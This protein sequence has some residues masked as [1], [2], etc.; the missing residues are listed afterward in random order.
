[1]SSGTKTARRYRDVPGTRTNARPTH[2]KSLS[3]TPTAEAGTEKPERIAMAST[4]KQ[5]GKKRAV[6]SDEDEDKTAEGSSDKLENAVDEDQDDHERNEAALDVLHLN[7]TSEEDGDGDKEPVKHS[8]PAKK[9]IKENP[10]ADASI[11]RFCQ[12]TL[13]LWPLMD[14]S[15]LLRGLHH[16][17]R[18]QLHP[19]LRHAMLR[20]WLR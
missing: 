14:P 10:D 20:C 3:I 19:S 17:L 6:E 2:A 8:A 9:K 12:I 11:C 18:E 15:N 1:M 4:R 7:F 5:K 16:H 13:H